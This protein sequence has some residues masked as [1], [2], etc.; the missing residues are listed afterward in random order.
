MQNG[1]VSM[2][3]YTSVTRARGVVTVPVDLRES[4]GVKQNTELTWVEVG[5]KLW[6]VGLA[7]QHPETVAP[8]VA[9]ALPAKTSPFSTLA[10]RLLSGD[11]PQRVRPG[12]R[13]AGRRLPPAPHLSEEQM[14]A[15]GEPVTVPARR[16]RR[17]ET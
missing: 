15:L 1:W 6:L 16:R 12:Y 3:V 2:R 14:I 13:R 10:R 9:A 7:E 8:I 17:R 11:I 5:P 4:A